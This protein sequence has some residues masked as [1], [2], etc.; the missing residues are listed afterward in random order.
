MAPTGGAD[1]AT[2]ESLDEGENEHSLFLPRSV[3]QETFDG[4]AIG[5]DV[6][7]G[8]D[9]VHE[10]VHELGE[11]AVTAGTEEATDPAVLVVV[12]DSEVALRGATT[13][14]G[15]LAA[16]GC[17]DQVVLVDRDPVGLL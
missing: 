8:G 10:L 2:E 1:P 12:V 6:G 9:Q 13:T 3:T 5:L 11:A 14:D 17:E 7:D 4:P 16:L 15:T